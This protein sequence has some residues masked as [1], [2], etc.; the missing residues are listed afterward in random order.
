M[1]PRRW[2]FV[3]DNRA[4]FGV[5]RICQVLGVSRCGYYRHQA[6]TQARA[7]RQAEQAAA[8][9]EIREIQP[10]ITAPTAPR[11]SMPNS[12]RGVGR[13]IASVSRA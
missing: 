3:S 5:K 13:S 12:A 10:N 8:V 6:T 7:A 9:A 1:S 4:D 11:A 2:D